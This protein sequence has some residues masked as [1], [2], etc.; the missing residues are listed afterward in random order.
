MP[1]LVLNMF[2]KTASKN[3]EN[4]RSLKDLSEVRFEEIANCDMGSLVYF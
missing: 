2:P 4:P 1:N 3:I